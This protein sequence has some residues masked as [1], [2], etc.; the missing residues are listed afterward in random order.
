MSKAL[1]PFVYKGSRG[2]CFAW[3][4]AVHVADHALQIASH[5]LQIASTKHASFAYREH[6]RSIR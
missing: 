5:A 2:L 6:F 1:L 4:G 3:K